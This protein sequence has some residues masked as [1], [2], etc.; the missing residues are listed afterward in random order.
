[1]AKTKWAQGFSLVVS[2]KIRERRCEAGMSQRALAGHVGVTPAAVCYYESASRT[3][4]VDVLIAIARALDF[5]IRDCFE[6]LEAAGVG[7]QKER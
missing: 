6:I 1:M 7:Q 4:S 3:P 2:R 5:S